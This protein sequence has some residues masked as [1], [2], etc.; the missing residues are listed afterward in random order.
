MVEMSMCLFSIAVFERDEKLKLKRKALE[1]STSDIF[2][3]DKLQRK[4]SVKNVVELL[5]NISSPVVFSVN[6]PWGAGKTTYLRMLH[7]S[8]KIESKKSI[9]FSAWETDFA[10]DPLV[11]F[12]G[13]MNVNI[14]AFTG[15]N[16]TK[17]KAWENAKKAGAQIVKKVIPVAIK[18]ATAGLIDAE[19]LLEEEA[20][21]L[22][23]ELSKDVIG[24]YTKNKQAIVDFKDNLAKILVSDDGQAEKL[25]IFVDE[26]DRCRPT[27]AIEL[28]ERIKHLLD[29]EGLVFVLALDKGQLAHSVKAIYGS[30]FDAAGYLKRFI[31]V[32]FSLP[33]S[34]IEPY[35]DYLADHFEFGDFFKAS[36]NRDIERQLPDLLSAI[37]VLA[38]GQGMSLRT[39][40]QLFAKI[41][42]VLLSVPK[43]KYAYPELVVY[44]LFVKDSFP[45]VY[46]DFIKKDSD[47]EELIALIDKVVVGGDDDVRYFKQ[48]TQALIIACKFAMG[49]DWSRTYVRNLR[50]LAALETS[51]EDVSSHCRRVADL[52]HHYTSMGRGVPLDRIVSQINMVGNFNFD[53]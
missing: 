47:G 21:K 14:C 46:S 9:Y 17:R 5:K 24:S 18:L 31:D 29:I 28:L 33:P 27:Y 53:R 50:E 13:E 23:E 26:L 4:E 52:V 40:E 16:S 30:D 43:G 48:D 45:D 8:L 10:E 2:V 36:N 32:E 44:L 22:A 7:S 49:A 3:N 38:R 6:A 42:L 1:I 39:I 34:D 19:K 37:K 35:I 11:A 25:Y 51:S 15:A 41:K 20:S 12:L